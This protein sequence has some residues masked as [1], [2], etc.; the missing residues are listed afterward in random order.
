MANGF[1]TAQNDTGSS[2][3]YNLPISDGIP[4][5]ESEYG[6]WGGYNFTILIA[7]LHGGRGER[8]PVSGQKSLVQT[9][10]TR[11]TQ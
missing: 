9:C 11:N 2:T 5:V 1:Q 4:L 10:C 8:L 6:I 7:M 3:K